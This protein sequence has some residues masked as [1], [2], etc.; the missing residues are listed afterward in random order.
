MSLYPP[1]D[2]T[3]VA[4]QP[5]PRQSAAA[6]VHRIA[7]M[8]ASG[9]IRA[10]DAAELRRLMPDD[11]SAP[12]FWK[13]MAELIMPV[14]NLP[15]RGPARDDAERRWAV[16]LNALAHLTG[17]DAPRRP[18]G[19]ALA[20]S[21]MSELRFAR[22]LRARGDRLAIEVRIAARFLASKAETANLTDLADLVLS[23]GHRHAESVRRRVARSYYNHMPND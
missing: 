9:A 1:I 20:A 7:A 14:L 2:V 13:L 21:G 17:L 11:A 15:S 4:M 10:G 12:A 22:L 18:L 19:D 16:V 23:D 5:T 6:V 8:L 3:V